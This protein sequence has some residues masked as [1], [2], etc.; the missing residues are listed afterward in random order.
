MILESRLQI[1]TMPHMGAYGARGMP[2]MM[3]GMTPG[4][5][6]GMAPGMRPGMAPGMAGALGSQIPG[7]QRRF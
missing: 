5:T 4:M 6:P 3:P 2:G 7:M 1:R